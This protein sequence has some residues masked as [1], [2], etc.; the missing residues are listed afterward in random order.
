LVGGG[1]L[2]ELGLGRLVAGVAVGVV[3]P[4]QLAVGLGDV[5]LAGGAAHPED[6]VQ[7]LRHG[8]GTRHD[9]AGCGRSCGHYTT[10]PG[11]P[12]RYWLDAPPAPS[13]ALRRRVSWRAW[14]IRRSPVTAR[15]TRGRPISSSRSCTRSCAGWRP[16]T[17][18][19]RPP[20]RRW[21]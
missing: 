14:T 8:G 7:V 11:R 9:G 3:L 17:S 15:P 6:I 19:P 1:D 12:P 18:R 13:V 20:G 10:P 2:L 5:G 21:T 16:T 4:G